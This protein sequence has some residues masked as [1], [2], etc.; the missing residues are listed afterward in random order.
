MIPEVLRSFHARHAGGSDQVFGRCR[1]ADGRT[2]YDWL[3][4]EADGTSVLDLACGDGPLAVRIADRYPG[5]EVVGLDGSEAEL[6][7]ALQRGHPRVRFVHGYAQE[8]PFADG[9]FDRVVSH[10]ALMLMDRFDDVMAEIR[11]VLRPGGTLSAVVGGKSEADELQ[12]GFFRE[13][14]RVRSA[15]MVL[16]DAR[17]HDE[18]GWRGLLAGWSD[19]RFDEQQLR[20]EVPADEAWDFLVV[21]YYPVDALT[22]DAKA[23]LR[24]WLTGAL[25]NRPLRWAFGARRVTATR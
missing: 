3:A 5:A 11:R 9:A 16:G 13:L 8:L 22:P 7:A 14:Q 4:D 19:L 1:V 23:E 20:V 2:S 6:A 15:P 24:S 17:T 21:S 12:R 25:G 18:D 10:M